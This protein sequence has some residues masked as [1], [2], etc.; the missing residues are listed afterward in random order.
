MR[1]IVSLALSLLLLLSLAACGGGGS[2]GG[3]G[4]GSGGT[5]PGNSTTPPEGSDAAYTIVIDG[6]DSWT[7][8]ES[9]SG[10]TFANS[11]ADV[12]SIS[13][14][15][16][17]V[18]FVGLTVGEAEITATFGSDTAKALVKVVKRTSSGSNTADEIT[19]PPKE[20]KDTTPLPLIQDLPGSYYIEYADE[21]GDVVTGAKGCFT[22]RDYAC[23]YYIDDENDSYPGWN[24]VYNSLSDDLVYWEGYG[25]Q[26][27]DQGEGWAADNFTTDVEDN[28]YYQTLC[29]FR[30]IILELRDAD[31]ISYYDTGRSEHIAGIECEIYEVHHNL[32][33]VEPT[34]HFAL[35]AEYAD[36]D[37]FMA[38]KFTAPFTEPNPLAPA[39]GTT[40]FHPSGNDWTFQR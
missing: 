23:S 12:I 24:G 25:W 17:T 28:A 5:A 8:F 18:T 13:D 32:Y 20:T 19:D 34:Y 21:D 27:H 39:N 26:D 40:I 36:G 29:S 11:K 37:G 14:D 30:Y 7:P 1:K 22:G 9:G 38:V 3:G 31:D 4:G 33:W 15:G 35:K 16:K 2:G 10:V 6:S